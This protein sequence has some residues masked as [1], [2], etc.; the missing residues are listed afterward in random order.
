MRLFISFAIVVVLLKISQCAEEHTFYVVLDM[1]GD[2]YIV[3]REPQSWVAQATY[4]IKIEEEGFAY[5]TLTSNPDYPDSVQ[6][7]CAGYLEG[8][9]TYKQIN[10]TFINQ[11]VENVKPTGD[12]KDFIVDN[13]NYV[14]KMIEENSTTTYWYQI[15]L[16][17]YQ[18]KGMEDGYLGLPAKVSRTI[19]PIGLF[20]IYNWLWTELTDIQLKYA[21]G[22]STL[23]S[24]SCSAMIRY[25]GDDLIASHVTW[26]EY[27]SMLRTMKKYNLKFKKNPTSND[28]IPGFEIL[29]SSYPGIVHSVDDYY[30][31]SEKLVV[32]ETTNSIQNDTLYDYIV[33]NGAVPYFLRVALANRL[34]ESG[35]DWTNYFAMY[36][37]GTY[38]NQWMVVDYKKFTPHTP[39]GPGTLYILEQMP[40][41]VV[42]KDMS[43][44]LE[45]GLNAWVSY[46][47]P[48]F[49]EVQEKNNY[50]TYIN[51]YGPFFSHDHSP[52]ANI[53]RRGLSNVTDLNSA[54][55]LMRYNDYQNDPYAKANCT[56]LAY[57]AENGISARC[58]LN[59]TN[60]VCAIAAEA[61]RCH[62]ATDLKIVGMSLVNSMQMIAISGPTYEQQEP[63]D[64]SKQKDTACDGILHEGHPTKFAFEP[65]LVDL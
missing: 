15:S 64:W 16:L 23:G 9:M 65:V 5:L 12:V 36:N 33:P 34:S 11:N 26:T 44:S 62:G 57:S 45:T 53:F 39:I 1:D 49:P 46:N 13:F 60:Q 4:S 30:V 42:T 28:T 52:R 41:F 17:V 59:P 47:I 10:Q 51:T 50:S 29:E 61:A 2:P 24:G 8:F 54:M 38:N 14:N 55:S 31:T 6:A 35:L 27:S 56:P 37:S 22:T 48:A 32:I 3:A 19:D 18:I 63:F 20:W 58:E 43:V 40:G 21:R 25:T 7:Y